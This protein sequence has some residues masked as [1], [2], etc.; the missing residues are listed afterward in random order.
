MQ[1]NGRPL[2]FRHLKPTGMEEGRGGAIY[3]HEHQRRASEQNREHQDNF[4][5]LEERSGEGK[6]LTTQHRMPP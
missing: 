5:L 4:M 1:N 6:S 3:H 2:S